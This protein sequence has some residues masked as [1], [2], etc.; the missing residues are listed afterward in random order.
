MEAGICAPSAAAENFTKT[1][2]VLSP[3]HRA[4]Y[5]QEFSMV[6][7]RLANIRRDILEASEKMRILQEEESRLVS[8]SQ[9]YTKILHPIRDVPDEI[10]REIFLACIERMGSVVSLRDLETDHDSLDPRNAPW[11]LGQVCR[12]WRQVTLSAPSLWTSVQ[13]A[14]PGPDSPSQTIGAMT[15]QLASCLRRSGSLPLTIVVRSNRPTNPHHPLLSVLYSHCSRWAAVRFQLIINDL[16]VFSAMSSIIKAD[17]PILHTVDLRLDGSLPDDGVIDAFEFAPLKRVN[18]YY[19][20]EGIGKGI[21]LKMPWTQVERF[22]RLTPDGNEIA[23]TSEP[24]PQMFNL[25]HFQDH[26]RTC[27]PVTEVRLPFLRTLIL[28][29]KPKT[30]PWGPG[31]SLDCIRPGRQLRDLRVSGSALPSLPGFLARSGSTVETLTFP[32]KAGVDV[33]ISQILGYVPAVTS[34][35]IATPRQGLIQCLTQCDAN[36]QPIF[37]PRLRSL[38]FCNTNPLDEKEFLKMVSARLAMVPPLCVLTFLKDTFSAETQMKLALFKIQ[39]LQ[40]HTHR[41]ANAWVRAV[42]RN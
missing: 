24:L 36:G 8:Y 42:P 10:L 19:K 2:D 33:D 16:S 34:L 23:V 5:Q 21:T 26:L 29:P 14:I 22:H 37:V 18:L 25:T 3:V 28:M 6:K 39:G 31:T 15:S 9:T 38:N 12:R 17:T 27:N 32:D 7:S 20:L 11:T 41:D 40:V 35:Y 4:I 30:A 13:F 1:N